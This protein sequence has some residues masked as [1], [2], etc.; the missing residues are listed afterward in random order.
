[1]KNSILTFVL[2]AIF[3]VLVASI[4]LIY[5]DVFY[6]TNNDNKRGYLIEKVD[7]AEKEV[8][9]IDFLTFLEGADI[10]K[11]KRVAKKCI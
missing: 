8:I 7:R 5:S 1:M 2:V 6:I 9:E 4:T 11:G 3:T 10:Q